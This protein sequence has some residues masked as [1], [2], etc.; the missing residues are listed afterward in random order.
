MFFLFTPPCALTDFN[1]GSSNVTVENSTTWDN[2]FINGINGTLSPPGNLSSALTAINGSALQNVLSGLQ[3]PTV[4]GTN[5][6]AVQALQCADGITLFIPENAAFTSAITSSLQGL[7][8][9]TTALTA[10]VQNLVRLPL[11]TSSILSSSPDVC[12]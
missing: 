4:N 10:V 5:V 6:S 12:V 7:Q 8:S 2:L 9:N 11:C 3:L 1:S